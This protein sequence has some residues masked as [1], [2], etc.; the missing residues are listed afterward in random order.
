MADIKKLN[1]EFGQ[2]GKFPITIEAGINGLPK[3]V[4]RRG[5]DCL[6]VYLHGAHVTACRL[7]GKE[8]FFLSSKSIFEDKKPIRGGIPVIFPQFSDQGALPKHGFVRDRE[9]TLDIARADKHSSSCILTTSSTPETLAVWPYKFS[10]DLEFRL[11][12][13]LEI[14]VSVVNCDSKPFR[15][16]FALHTYFHVDDIHNVSVSGL[17]KAEYIDSIDGRRK[18][19]EAPPSLLFSGEVDRVYHLPDISKT[20]SLFG[21]GSQPP[22]EID[23]EELPD[24]V[25]WNP[26]I[27]KSKTLPD[28]GD[29]EYKKFVCVETGAILTPLELPA[30]D[31]WLASTFI[32]P[33]V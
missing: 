33:R 20:V 26:W 7:G 23:R 4:L 27:D 12:E 6:E 30:G 19:T 11:A 15:F 17:Q 13:E 22:L 16:Q 9:W 8:I 18:K 24:V 29:D 32:S 2:D 28:L 10:I 14:G 1:S 25:V 3:V 5:E 31:E 21:G